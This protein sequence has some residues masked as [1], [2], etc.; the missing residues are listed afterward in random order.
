V[1]VTDD[2]G[3]DGGAFYSHDGRSLV[4]RATAW[5]PGNEI[6]E[7]AAYRDDLKRWQVRPSQME[8]FTIAPDGTNRQQVT[9]LGGAS[10]APYFTPDDKR[11]IFASNHHDENTPQVN[12]DIFLIDRDG[13][14]LER[15]TF[16]NDGAGKKFD[17]FPMFS[18]NGRYLAFS[19]NRG[20]DKPGDTNVF[21]AEWT[22]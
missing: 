12:F 16:F 3:Y 17:A 2:L 18:R 7:Q 4:F 5:T 1:Q 13:K 15:V 6:A 14:N 21:I 9:T 10:F 20:N 8:I 19:S 22:P 11:I